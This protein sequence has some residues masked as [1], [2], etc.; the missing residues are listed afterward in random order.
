MD[1]VLIDSMNA[2]ARAW[3]DTCARFGIEIDE[4]EVYRREGE[5]EDLSAR[6]YLKQA[7]LMLTKARVAELVRAKN[8]AFARLKADRLFPGA[9]DVVRSFAA[10][11]WRAGVVTGSPRVHFERLL[12][13]SL[14][15][16]LAVSVCG[17]EV[18]RG[19]PNPEPY[20]AAMMSLGVKPRQT[21]VVENAPFGI[22]SARTAGAHVVAL[23]SF[24]N[25]EDLAGAHRFA[26]DIREL[27]ALF[28]I[29]A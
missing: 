17:D 18:L 19:K 28:G 21:V 12:P 29:P 24:L 3:T 27:P 15:S 13:E 8:E 22:Q 1:G 23:R 7:G 20:M 10:A 11:G 16:V 25:D 4:R 14:R 26:D 2:H 6:F 9:V 5:K